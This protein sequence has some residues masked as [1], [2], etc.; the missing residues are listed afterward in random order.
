MLIKKL[1]IKAQCYFIFTYT[2]KTVLTKRYMEQVCLKTWDFESID[3]ENGYYS[4][5]TSHL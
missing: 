1:M 5:F 4:F 2:S 3:L